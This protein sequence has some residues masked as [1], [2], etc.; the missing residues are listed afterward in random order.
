MEEFEELIKNQAV[1]DEVQQTEMP[2][3]EIRE[4]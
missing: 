3:E 4:Q 2:L 1:A